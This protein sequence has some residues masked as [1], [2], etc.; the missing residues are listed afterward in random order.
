MQRAFCLIRE[1]SQAPED[2]NSSLLFHAK[3]FL[4]LVRSS[5]QS[6]YTEKITLGVTVL[7]TFTCPKNKTLVA[8]RAQSEQPDHSS[9]LQRHDNKNR[10]EAHPACT[11]TKPKGSKAKR[12]AK[13]RRELMALRRELAELLGV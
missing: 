13:V 2:T 3:N 10:S 4:N 6:P 7:R 1:D 11:Q 8:T 12:I 5:A 9:M